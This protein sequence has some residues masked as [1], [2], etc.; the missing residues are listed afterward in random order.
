[1]A[2]R[3]E[4]L[5]A[6]RGAHEAGDTEAATRIAGMLQSAPAAPPAPY[7]PDT[8][9]V[10]R[11]DEDYGNEGRSRPATLRQTIERLYS[12]GAGPKIGKVVKDAGVGLFKGTQELVEGLDKQVVAG[13]ASPIPD[14]HPVAQAA[15]SYVSPES[16]ETQ[17]LYDEAGP[18]AGVTRVIPELAVSAIPISRAAKVV[19]RA[20]PLAMSRWA[21]AVGDIAANAVYEGGKSAAQG[22]DFT[23]AGTDALKGG[24]GALGGRVLMR[25]LGGIKPL[26]RKESQ[27]LIDN[28]VFPTPGQAIGGVAGTIEDKLLSLPILGDI[29]QHARRRSISDF[30]RAETNEALS[31]FQKIIDSPN[32]AFADA[33]KVIGSPTVSGTGTD[34]ID[35]AEKKISAAYSTALDGMDMG[36]KHVDDAIGRTHEAID[37]IPLLDERQVAQLNHYINLRV[38]PH[39]VDGFV[40]G[41]AAKALDAEMGHYARKYSR[42][43]NPADHSLGEAFYTLQTNWR[44]QMAQAADDAGMSHKTAL[45]NAANDAYRRLLPLVK[46]S[47][48]AM[49]QGGTFTPLQLARAHGPYGQQPSALTTSAQAV[50]PSRVPDS[51]TAGRVMMGAITGGAGIA[52]AGM[53]AT[54]AAGLAAYALTSRTGLRLLYNGLAPTL[55][56]EVREW[57]QKLPPERVAQFFHEYGKNVPSVNQMAAQIGRHLATQQQQPQEATQ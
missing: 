26:L 36:A 34:A 57:L 16:Q 39:T 45:L 40:S 4:M 1:M 9:R 24:A 19:E 46:A 10:A 12:E 44:S 49:A 25:A 13:P 28:G 7:A 42:S 30:G 22:N 53:G 23:T 50:L 2:T 29:G 33:R 11:P 32:P 54:A 3:D 6:L 55:K 20:L 31:P 15:R 5:S 56:P 14:A 8:E 21:P 27:D 52:G 35:A 43:V 51:G 47:D 37:N 38:A 48:R 17:R 18:V 41:E